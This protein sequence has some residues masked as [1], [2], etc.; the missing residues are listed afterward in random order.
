MTKNAL[1]NVN[2]GLVNRTRHVSFQMTKIVAAE[3][4]AKRKY[5]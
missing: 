5:G 3:V 2:N 1:Q 4:L